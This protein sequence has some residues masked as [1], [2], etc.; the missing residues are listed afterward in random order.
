[1]KHAGIILLFCWCSV[2]SAVHPLHLSITNIVYENGKLSIKMKTFMDDWEVAYFHY[3]GDT[4]HFSDPA[5]RAGPWFTAYLERSFRISLEKDSDPFPLVVDSMELKGEYM[6]PDGI[7][8]TISMSASLPGEP[9][10][11]YIYNPLLTDIYPDQ[12]NLVIFGYKKRETGMK[13]DMKKQGDSI[14]LK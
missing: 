13:F 9:K 7:T 10:T 12:T 8:M 4:I 5:N 14:S 3:H 2:C 1:M 11:L 6:N